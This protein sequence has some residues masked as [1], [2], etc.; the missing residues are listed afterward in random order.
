MSQRQAHTAEHAFIGALQ[1][2]LGTVIRVRKVE[3]KGDGT[4]TAFIALHQLDVDTVV[5]AEN[6][7]NSLI[8]EGRTIAARSYPSLEEARK[9]NP[10]LRAN[11]ERISGEVRVI[12]IEG[13]DVTACA[14]EH[15][16]NLKECEFFLATRLSRSGGEYEVDFVVGQ[17]AREAAVA[18]SARMMKVCEELGA[19]LNTVEATARKVRAEGENS[20][21]KLKTL[22]KD[23]LA[24][25]APTTNNSSSIAVF[26]GVFSGLDDETVVEFAGARIASPNTVV[27]IA[28]RGGQGDGSN[29]RFVFA[30]SDNLAAM[31][32]NKI[33]RE[34]AG[35]DG[36]GGGKPNFVTGILNKRIE[37]MVDGM[38]MR[39]S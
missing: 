35:A 38:A 23:A 39:L 9:Q 29:A 36:R 31:D 16:S 12:E 1:K 2:M 30:R 22:S 8:T 25:I 24:G 18:L 14:M 13:H 10:G 34:V 17:Q 26:K 20:S 6:M 19:N 27:I 5:R 11:E 4:N 32:C 3:H 28:N 21:R 33:F 7:V 15:A 37:E